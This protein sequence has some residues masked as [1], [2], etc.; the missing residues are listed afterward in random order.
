MAATTGRNLMYYGKLLKDHP[1]VVEHPMA[2]A[3]SRPSP[4]P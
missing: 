4:M 1:L 2:M 3:P